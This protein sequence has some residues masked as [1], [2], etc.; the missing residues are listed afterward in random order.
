[1]NQH[2]NLV[3]GGNNY[4]YSEFAMWTMLQNVLTVT[5]ATT[6]PTN[7]AVS[8]QGRVIKPS[9]VRHVISVG[10]QDQTVMKTSMSV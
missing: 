1:M 3:V 9:D 7:A 4:D 10:G 8:V 5:G 2:C 6:V